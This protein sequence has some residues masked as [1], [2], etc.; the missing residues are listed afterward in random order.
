M[1]TPVSIFISSAPT[2]P[3]QELHAEL[4]AYLATV[5]SPAL[6]TWN[7]RRTADEEHDATPTSLARAQV[8]L[9]LVS[10]D[11]LSSAKCRAEV[12][13]ALARHD[14]G[15]ARV[16]PILARA[17]PW[18]QQPFAKLQ[19]IPREGVPLTSWKSREESWS[20]VVREIRAVV[21]EAH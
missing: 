14:A 7:P 19:S 10:I 16:V 18:E 12:D 9:L 1:S 3:D 5:L 2:P 13:Q 4:G 6:A 21:K 8:V 15:D 17:C 20:S 11:Y